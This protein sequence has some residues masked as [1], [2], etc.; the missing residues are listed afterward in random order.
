MKTNVLCL[1]LIGFFGL[2]CAT[3]VPLSDDTVVASEMSVTTGRNPVLFVG[4][5]PE[6]GQ[7]TMVTDER[8]SG[9]AVVY[10]LFDDLLA[11]DSTLSQVKDLRIGWQA[12]RLEKGAPWVK[13]PFSMTSQV[14]KH[15]LPQNKATNRP[16]E[17]VPIRPEHYVIFVFER[18]DKTAQGRQARVDEKSVSVWLVEG[19]ESI[20]ETRLWSSSL[21]PAVRASLDSLVQ[22]CGL[23]TLKGLY[24]NPLSSGGKKFRISIWDPKRDHLTSS[25]LKNCWVPSLYELCSCINS[26]L[27]KRYAMDLA[28]SELM[29]R[30]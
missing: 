15:E 9:Q 29:K 3:S 26:L 18:D 2:N 11:M 23:D 20:V 5:N 16:S 8:A 21:P 28:V 12:T 17:P 7:W 4:R 19:S 22:R 24:S 25:E 30:Q 1:F 13:E 10:A 14:T 27:P 6:D